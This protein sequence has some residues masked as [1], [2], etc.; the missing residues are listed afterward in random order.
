MYPQLFPRNKM[1]K[2]QTHILGWRKKFWE[3]L[4]V[5]QLL[6]AE[7]QTGRASDESGSVLY[8]LNTSFAGL[9]KAT[10]TKIIQPEICSAQG[11]VIMVIILL[12]IHF[13]SQLC[14]THSLLSNCRQVKL[15][16]CSRNNTIYVI[17]AKFPEVG[18]KCGNRRE[19]I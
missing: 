19:E 12:R 16:L 5:S 18:T 4:R 8:F 17:Q 6:S 15:G 13:H 3:A 1:Q 2:T 7:Q 10:T 9:F 11:S 14:K